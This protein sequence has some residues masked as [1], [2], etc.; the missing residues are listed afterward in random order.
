MKPKLK[1]LFLTR[2]PKEGASSRYRVYQYLP[3]LESM[4]VSCT[5]QSFM[6]LE[7]YELYFS[8]GSTLRKMWFL[9]RALAARLSSLRDYRQ[10]DIIY[11]QR[12]LFPIGPPWVERY[13]RKKGMKLIFDYDDALFIK[14]PSRYNPLAT[15]FRSPDKTLKIFDLVD[16]VVAGNDWL[17]DKAL[18]HGVEAVTVEVAEDTQRIQMHEP[19][20]NDSPITIGWLGSRS[21]VKYLNSIAPVL[22]KISSEYSNLVFEL[23]GGGKYFMDGVPWQVSEWS[24]DGELD[25]L[26][27]FD[28]GL[29]PLPEEP[30]SKGK[31]GGKARTYMAA[32]VVPVCTGYGYN[33]ELITDKETGY[34]CNSDSDWYTALS[35]LI[36]S[37]ELRQR[38]AVKARSEVEL[39]FSPAKQA[40]VLK[41]VFDDVSGVRSA[42]VRQQAN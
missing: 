11:M 6:D 14:K 3:Y 8:P 13:F 7:M 41:N 26:A 31:S 38:I 21:T 19:H 36:E 15:L 30:W 34:L 2:Y 1:V 20:R 25:A 16:C 37:A 4:G 40:Q 29:M 35:S 24:L 23:V 27:R 5:S 39:R 28:V 17:R 9:I 18:D 12:E 32:G 33:L 22:R 10:Y 42:L